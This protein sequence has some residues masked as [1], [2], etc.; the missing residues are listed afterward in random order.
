MS[1]KGMKK[2][3]PWQEQF[4]DAMGINEGLDGRAILRSLAHVIE[5]IHLSPDESANFTKLM[6]DF[7][8]E[9]AILSKAWVCYF[10]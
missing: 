1:G 9:K 2:I 8:S 10:R 7:P 3:Y 5:G 4:G 6:S